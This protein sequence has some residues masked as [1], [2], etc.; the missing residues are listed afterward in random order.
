M[1]NLFNKRKERLALFQ[2]LV[3]PFGKT[4]SKEIP[5]NIFYQC[6]GCGKNM[7]HM[8][9]SENYFICPSCGF[10][11]KI[12]ARQ[13]I[14]ML[15]DEGSFREMYE[16]LETK[17]RENFPGYKEKLTKYKEATGLNEAVVCGM[18]QID[19]I[20]CIVAVMDSNFMMGSMGSVVGEK[21]TRTI[22]FATKRKYPLIIS[23]TS[24]G[25]RMQ[26]GI[27]SLMQ[28]AKTSAAIK[29]HNDNGLLY[30]SLITHPTTGGVSASF[31]MLGDIILAEPGALIGFAGKRV[32][33][34]TINETLPEEFQTAEFLVEKGFVDRIVN[35][36][37]MKNSIGNILKLHEGR[38]YGS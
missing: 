20:K 26:E 28:M 36:R 13:R 14:E 16:K 11:L 38:R 25:A 12:T 31:A 18:G 9:L 2:K 30:I 6:G 4:K 21:L 33:E 15:L 27:V 24:G 10:H 34:K 5:D 23:C 32:I 37:D 22:E 3:R 29:R 1:N 7:N 19:G 8:D 35:R 17:D